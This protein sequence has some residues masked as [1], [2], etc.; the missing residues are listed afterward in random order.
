MLVYVDD[1]IIAGSSKQVVDKLVYVLSSSF[2]LKDFGRLNYFLGFKVVHN[3][4]GI[5]LLQHKY[6][7][8]LL[9]GAH[10]ENCRTVSTPMSVIEKLASNYGRP[11]AEEDVFKYRSMFGGLQYLTLTRPDISFAVNKVCQYL[12]KPTDLHWEA[13]KRI[14]RYVKGIVSTELRIRQSKSML[15]SVFTDAD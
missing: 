11:L 8:D 4:G 2:P 14:L 13:V 12:S 7:T 10:M 1:I 3:S 15:L 9:Y 5:T 6:A